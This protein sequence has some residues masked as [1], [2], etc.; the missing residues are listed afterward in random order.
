V[1]GLR[2]RYLEVAPTTP[3][4]PETWYWHQV[5]GLEVRTGAGEVVGRVSDVFRAGE[6]EVYVV[7]GGPRGEVLVPA[8]RGVVTELRPDAGYLVVD[9]RALGLEAASDDTDA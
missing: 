6:G 7:T 1:E 9:P 8:V 4:P 2:D 3:L 5:E